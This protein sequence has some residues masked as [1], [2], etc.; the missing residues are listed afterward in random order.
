MTYLLFN[1][2][3]L[4]QNTVCLRSLRGTNT[5]MLDLVP[6][7]AIPHDFSIGEAVTVINHAPDPAVAGLGADEGWYEIKHIAS[8]KML[9]AKYC[10]SKAAGDDADDI[11]R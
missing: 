8:G 5:V 10:G 9:R 11:H 2:D 6:E 1:I 7:Q 3:A 4:D